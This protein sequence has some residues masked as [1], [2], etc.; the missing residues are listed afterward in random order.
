MIQQNATIYY[1]TVVLPR[2]VIDKFQPYIDDRKMWD[3]ESDAIT[4]RVVH[5]G[6]GFEININVVERVENG[7]ID[8]YVE[9]ILFDRKCEVYSWKYGN[10]LTGEC[11]SS[12]LDLNAS[13]R[14]VVEAEFDG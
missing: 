8:A 7:H 1:E 9:V 11:S 2:E 5:L 3:F 12:L 13:F 10:K 6:D 14:L 4:V